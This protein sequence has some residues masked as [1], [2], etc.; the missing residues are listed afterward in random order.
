MD[1]L[2]FLYSIQDKTANRFGPL[3]E[4][5]NDDVA[6]RLYIQQINKVNEQFRDEYALYKVGEYNTL[7]GFI[8]PENY[9]K[10]LE[11]P[12]NYSMK[13]EVKANE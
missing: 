7:T 6:A 2:C 9:P 8:T 11:L 4:A 3:F 13:K 10:K 12:Y 5:I 1:N